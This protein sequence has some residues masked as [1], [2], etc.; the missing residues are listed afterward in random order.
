[1]G[2][3]FRSEA[4]GFIMLFGIRGNGLFVVT[5]LNKT[6]VVIGIYF[7][8]LISSCFIFHIHIQQY[9]HFQVSTCQYFMSLFQRYMKSIN[10]LC[11]GTR[12]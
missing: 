11:K 3:R 1:M 2:K 10:T 4:F 5:V 9:S 7:Y 12:S 8:N 6:I